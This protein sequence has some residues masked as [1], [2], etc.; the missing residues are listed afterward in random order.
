MDPKKILIIAASLR[1]GGAEKVARDIALYGPPGEYEYHYVVF[2]DEVGAYE[3]ELTAL[4][5][6]IFH[7]APPRR[8][9]RAYWKSLVHLMAEHRYHAVHAHNMFNCGIVMA[10][11][12]LSRV[13]ARISHAHSALDEPGGL[14]TTLYEWSMRLLI[15]TC[16]TDLVACGIRAGHRLFGPA[17]WNRRGQLVLNGI[18]VSAYRSDPGARQAI[19]RRLGAEDAFLIGHTG[20]MMPVKNQRFLIGLMPRILKLRPDARLLLL[21]DGPDRETLLEL[22]RTLGLESFVL[23]PG[24]VT[25]VHLWLSAMDVFVFPSLYEGMPLSVMEAQANG[26]PCILSDGVPADVHLT[27]LIRVLPLSAPQEQWAGAICTAARPGNADPK[28][29]AGFDVR[30]SMEKIHRIYKKGS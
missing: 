30:G 13:P 23:M 5:C 21:G 19:R 8:S 27:S 29:L 11:A 28:A 12:L 15:R 9:Y 2:G 22:V 25:D 10:A 16:S 3:E 1:I 6:R 4:G 17:A 18:D 7:L 24:N 20:H 26:L 14:G